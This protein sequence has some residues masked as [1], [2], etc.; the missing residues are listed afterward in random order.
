MS[1]DCLNSW[2]PQD[3]KTHTQQPFNP[4]PFQWHTNCWLKKHCWVSATSKRATF[5]QHSKAKKNQQKKKTNNFEKQKL[6]PCKEASNYRQQKS[7]TM[8]VSLQKT[9]G[10]LTKLCYKSWVWLE[11][12][13]LQMEVLL[14][15]PKTPHNH[16]TSNSLVQWRRMFL[17]KAESRITGNKYFLLRSWI[18][19]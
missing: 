19:W 17:Q 8:R 13:P 10:R 7:S 18:F 4:L 14:Q 2:P 5:A 3:V 1:I 9:F 11:H 12:M 16:R 6:L 15:R